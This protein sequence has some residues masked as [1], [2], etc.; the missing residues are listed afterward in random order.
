MGYSE[1]SVKKIVVR[2]L[3]PSL[4]K[5][6]FLDIVSPLAEYDYI[7]YSNADTRYIIFKKYNTL[8]IH[9]YNF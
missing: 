5:E 4:T 9:K 2:R 6:Q 7:Y 3:P 1:N 8:D